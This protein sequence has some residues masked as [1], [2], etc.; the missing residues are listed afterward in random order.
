MTPKATGWDERH[1]AEDPAVELLQS[2]GYTYI[3]PDDL[4]R[5][6]TSFKEVIL[7]T[8]LATALK[9]LNPWLSESNIAKAVKT[10]TQVP[11]ASLAEANEALYTSLSYGIALEQ[12]RGDGRKSHSVRFLDSDK[13]SRNEWIVTDR[14]KLDRQIAGVF[15]TCGFPNPERADSVR[16]LRQI[17]AHPTGKTVMTTIQKFQEITGAAG[18]ARRGSGHPTLSEAENIFV[19]VDEAHRTQYRSLAANMRQALPNAAFLGFTGT[20]PSTRR[21]EARCTPSAPTSTPWR[22]SPPCSL[23]TPTRGGASPQSPRS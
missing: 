10:V 18:G 16:D 22:F 21:I 12:V 5:E 3:A 15:E 2:I 8:R 13:P 17:L 4:E 1:L 9:R 23:R 11:A 6:R 19:M 14:T 7:T 20:P